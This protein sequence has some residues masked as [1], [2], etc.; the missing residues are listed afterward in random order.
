M[1][2]S[3][4]YIRVDDDSYYLLYAKAGGAKQH[5][6]TIVLYI[7]TF[8]AVFLATMPLLYSFVFLERK[9]ETSWSTVV[10][11]SS[12]PFSSFRCR[13][14]PTTMWFCRGISSFRSCLWSSSQYSFHLRTI[15]TPR[16]THYS[17]KQGWHL[18]VYTETPRTKPPQ[19]KK[20]KKKRVAV[21]NTTVRFSTT[22]FLA[23]K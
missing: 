6:F 4:S 12:L 8:P 15:K 3:V 13:K 14:W 17:T 2:I 21:P 16:R 23:L 18:Q 20:K 1:I 19:Q 7:S 10:L 9:N 11:L 22:R 5:Q